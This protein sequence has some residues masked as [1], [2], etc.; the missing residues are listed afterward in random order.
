MKLY[1]TYYVDEEDSIKDRLGVF[2]TYEQALE[3]AKEDLKE[4]GFDE[5]EHESFLEY[6]YTIENSDFTNIKVEFNIQ[7]D[8]DELERRGLTHDDLINDITIRES[9]V[10]DGFEITRRGELGDVLTDFFLM[11]ADNFKV[12]IQS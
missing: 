11:K 10:V 5:E 7:V 8:T 9:E 4:R 3:C 12:D 1:S 6:D 2:S